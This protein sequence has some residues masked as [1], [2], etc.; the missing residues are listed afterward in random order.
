MNQRRTL[1]V[2]RHASTEDVRTGSKDRERSLTPDGERD[3]L[4][5][6]DYLRAQGIT[7]DAVLCSS[8]ARARQTLEL[9]KL[10][11]RLLQDR[12]EIA[13]RF[14]NAGA[15]TLINAVRELPDDSRVALLVGHAPGAPGVVYEL[16][17]P[18]TSRAEAMG[19]IEG[20][21]PAAALARLEFDGD[22]SEVEA[23]SLV[24]VRMPGV[25]GC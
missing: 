1:L 11:D 2:L 13:D 12:V 23:A 6:G 19:A 21:F 9:L 14:Y 22:W 10:D 15:D 3:A 17:D 7:V 8:A 4:E 16:A 25:T 24:S 18:T 20:R 5:L